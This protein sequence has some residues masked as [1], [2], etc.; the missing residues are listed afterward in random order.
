MEGRAMTPEEVAAQEKARERP[1][2]DPYVLLQLQNKMKG[3]DKMGQSQ[4]YTTTFM[5]RRSI[6]PPGGAIPGD[7]GRGS[8]LVPKGDDGGYDRYTVLATPPSS[9]ANAAGGGKKKLTAK[10]KL[11]DVRAALGYPD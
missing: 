2:L 6:G 1:P 8:L 4:V 7:L 3:G 5:S 10:A 9:S 11:K